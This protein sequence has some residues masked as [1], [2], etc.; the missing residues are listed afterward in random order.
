MCACKYTDVRES[1]NDSTLAGRE[2]QG[3]RRETIH[4]IYHQSPISSVA[5]HLYVFQTWTISS[6]LTVITYIICNII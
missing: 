1:P 5:E 6:L 4:P 3:S 2:G